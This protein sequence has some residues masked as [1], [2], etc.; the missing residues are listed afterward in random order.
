MYLAAHESLLDFGARFYDPATAIF[1][2]QDPLA[3]KYYNISPY[4][5]CANNP[6]NFVDPDGR[7]IGFISDVVSVGIG[8]RSLIQNIQSG[9]LRAA[10]FDGAGIVVD[11]IAV[12]VPVIPGGVGYIR[13]GAKVSNAVDDAADAAKAAKTVGVSKTASKSDSIAEDVQSSLIKTNTSKGGENAATRL[14]REKHIEYNP[15]E[16]YKKEYK[17]SSGVKEQMLSVLKKAMSEN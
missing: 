12:A 1:L 6:V 11:V 9:D 3:E 5:Y 16:G 15:G 14:G 4:A 2:Q 8:V 13:A 10:V 7:V 17:L